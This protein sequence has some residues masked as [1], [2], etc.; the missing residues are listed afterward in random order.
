M[1]KTIGWLTLLCGVFIGLLI[2]LSI[3]GME[4]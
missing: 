4:M 2:S 3:V 1:W